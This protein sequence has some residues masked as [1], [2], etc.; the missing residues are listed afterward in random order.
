MQA[1]LNEGMGYLLV[2]H[3]TGDLVRIHALPI[4]S[5]DGRRFA[6]ASEDLE[7]RYVPNAIQIWRIA[8]NAV[9]L[10]WSLEPAG[11]PVVITP[12]AW[13]PAN[14]RWTSP[15]EIRVQKVTYDPET[16]QKLI[17]DEV[18]IRRIRGR[19][20]VSPETSSPEK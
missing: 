20:R 15:T 12:D 19:W 5:P 10:E 11:D 2:N 7:S 17:G 4:V 3:G 13:G 14:L 16:F 8:E 6:T 18:A 1:H 9:V